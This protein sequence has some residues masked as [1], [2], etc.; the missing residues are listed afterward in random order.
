M[1]Q[2]YRI[3]FF[4]QHKP[5]TSPHFHSQSQAPREQK[6]KQEQEPKSSKTTAI[7]TPFLLSNQKP[8]HIKAKASASQAT[9]KPLLPQPKHP[10]RAT[11]GE[12][13]RCWGRPTEPGTASNHH[14]PPRTAPR[15][16]RQ[17][18]PRSTREHHTTASINII[19]AIPRNQPR[20][21][22]VVHH[23]KPPLSFY[24]KESPQYN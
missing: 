23:P 21:I 16:Q 17:R 10:Q 19:T 14:K 7:P 18:G 6:L 3:F 22:K 9:V 2:Y 5:L 8:T 24:P 11:G 13:Q 15:R 1:N 12:E 4:Q 20:T